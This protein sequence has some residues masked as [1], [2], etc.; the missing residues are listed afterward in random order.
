MWY[1]TDRSAK[2]K[3]VAQ[4]RFY[5]LTL[6][7][8][9]SC[10][11]DKPFKVHA[12]YP[13]NGTAALK[14]LRACRGGWHYRQ[15]VSRPTPARS[16]K[17][18]TLSGVSVGANCILDEIVLATPR[19]ICKSTWRKKTQDSLRRIKIK[20]KLPL[21]VDSTLKPSNFENNDENPRFFPT[22]ARKFT[23]FFGLD[24]E[25]S[26]APS[27]PIRR[28]EYRRGANFSGYFL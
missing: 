7:E 11:G 4:H 20:Q 24:P 15:I 18:S 23:R 13:R 8:Q 2:Q 1:H 28:G 16:S 27:V 17:R 26:H 12:V 19:H 5:L 10:F 14:G 22:K 21:K 25:T 3:R 9:Q 6:L